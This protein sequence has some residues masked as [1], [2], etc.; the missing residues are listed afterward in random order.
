MRILVVDDSAAMRRILR[1]HLQA[2]GH[3]EVTEAADG[4]AALAA[5]A[6]TPMDLV[7]TDCHMP[8]MTGLEL[9]TMIRAT[10]GWEAIPI[11]M[12]TAVADKTN[13]LQAIECGVTDYLRKPFDATTL[14]RKVAQVL[15]QSQATQ[16][17]LV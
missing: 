14:Q 4:P 11:L 8:G 6:A 9:V 17:D 13:V 10:P 2:L 3:T 15:D 16:R 7:L 12:V 1:K 5:M